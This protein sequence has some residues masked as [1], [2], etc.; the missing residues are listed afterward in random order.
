MYHSRDRKHRRTPT[1]LPGRL[2]AGGP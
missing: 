1:P 2:V